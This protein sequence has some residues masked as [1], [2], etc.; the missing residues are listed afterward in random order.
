MSDSQST[1]LLTI[2]IAMKSDIEKMATYGHDIAY[3]KDNIDMRFKFIEDNIDRVN[4]ALFGQN[5]NNGIIG[6]LAS[7]KKDHDFLTER[8]DKVDDKLDKHKRN[9]ARYM[10]AIIS[11]G[12]GVMVGLIKYFEGKFT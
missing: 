4:R 9:Y 5:F 7:L 2:I 8:A 1:E 6:D 11:T 12:T 3:I 10:I